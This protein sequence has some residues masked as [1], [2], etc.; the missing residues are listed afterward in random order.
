MHGFFFVLFELFIYHVQFFLIFAEFVY[1][2]V[3]FHSI[4]TLNT[5][6]IYLYMALMV[7]S[8]FSLG[9][10]GAVGNIICAIFFVFQ[11][12]FYLFVGMF[13]TCRRL[14]AFKEEME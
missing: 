12:A 5:T 9:Y 1:A 6:W 2:F 11:I 14:G 8:V 10:I 4:M 7:S 13:L 3:A